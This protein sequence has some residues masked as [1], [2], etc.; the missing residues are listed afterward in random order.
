MGPLAGHPGGTLF[1]CAAAGPRARLV[2]GGTQVRTDGF[3]LLVVAVS[4]GGL[5]D[6]VVDAGSDAVAACCAAR[7][8]LARY[9]PETGIS[10]EYCINLYSL[11]R[12]NMMQNIKQ[13]K[14][15]KWLNNNKKKPYQDQ[16]VMYYIAD[17]YGQLIQVHELSVEFCNVILEW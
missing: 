15:C 16:E 6:T 14:E 10:A 12:Q 9:P 13:N 4:Q 1:R 3:Q 5:S 7:S 11:N 8:P 2:V 17:V